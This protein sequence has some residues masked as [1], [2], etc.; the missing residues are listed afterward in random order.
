ML[1]NNPAYIYLGVKYGK[2]VRRVP[3]GTPGAV[4]RTTKAGKVVHEVQ[5]DFVEGMLLAIEE[6]EHAVYGR[7]WLLTLQ[8]GAE[9]YRLQ[10]QESSPALTSLLHQLPG[11]DFTKP[12][13]IE[14]YD[15]TDN[16]KKN[17]AGVTL[18]Q[19]KK[20]VERFFTREDPKGLPAAKKE[21]AIDGK[22]TWDYSEQ[23]QFLRRYVEQHITPQLPS[24]APQPELPEIPELP[25]MPDG[26]PDDLPFFFLKG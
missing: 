8:D 13:K 10:L 16:D 7:Q 3:E 12:I 2:I 6:Q 18:K 20:K 14:P 9:V 21:V 22:E 17:H 25:D 24:F 4:Q 23:L 15:F 19:G 26:N 5:R 1:G 11:C